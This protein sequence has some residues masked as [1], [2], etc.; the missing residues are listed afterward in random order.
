MFQA[1]LRLSGDNPIDITFKT[2]NDEQ[3]NLED[4]F[5]SLEVN[6]TTRP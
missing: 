2:E 3:I 5:L 1:G 6:T 4:S